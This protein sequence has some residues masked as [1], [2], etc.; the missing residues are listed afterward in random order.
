MIEA[1]VAIRREFPQAEVHVVMRG[2][3]GTLDEQAE[4]AGADLLVYLDGEPPARDDSH[5][6]AVASRVERAVSGDALFAV[7]QPV[8]NLR[9]GRVVGLEAFARFRDGA[10]VDPRERLEEAQTVGL[11]REL[12]VAALFA[13]VEHVDLLPLGWF[14][15]ANLS[16]AT[17]AWTQFLEEIDNLPLGRMWIEVNIRDEPTAWF[18]RFADIWPEGSPRPQMALDDTGA[19]SSSLKAI[20]QLEPDVVKVAP[21]LIRGIDHRPDQHALVS[22]IGVFAKEVGAVLLAE[23]VE[24]QAEADCLASLGV[25]LAQGFLFGAPDTIDRER[26]RELKHR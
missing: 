22:T 2:T 3:G 4:S 20:H 7:Y 17:L 14:L 11:R 24:S 19:T 13:A 18:G 10:G 25:R 5:S 15:A 6:R 12:E 9:T 1:V 26:I 16:P 21:E 23:G 8:V